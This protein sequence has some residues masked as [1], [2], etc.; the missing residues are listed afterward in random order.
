M[1]KVLMI[2]T[3]GMSTS[4]FTNKINKL[5][6]DNNIPVEV[7]AKGEGDIETE[8]ENNDIALLL[9]GP[10]AAYIET[11]IRKRVNGRVPVDLVDSD[12][13]GKQRVD[14]VLKQIIKD[15]KEAK[16]K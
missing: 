8:L 1:R 2:C 5:A 7:Y 14:I 9:I 3:F 12:D 4:F 11:E 10:Q 13:F 16:N 6:K 15:I